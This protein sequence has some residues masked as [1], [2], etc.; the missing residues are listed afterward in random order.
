MLLKESF[1]QLT[2]FNILFNLIN[3]KQSICADTMELFKRNKRKKVKECWDALYIRCQ[4]VSH[5]HIIHYAI[6][7][8]T[9]IINAVIRPRNKESIK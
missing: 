3:T 2:Q 8:I 7:I 4:L 1:I 9:V 5:V 6:V